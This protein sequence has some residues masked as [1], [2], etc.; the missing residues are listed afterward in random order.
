MAEQKTEKPTQQRLQ[1]A[2]R[3]GKFASSRDLYSAVQFVL[4]F[5]IALRSGEQIYRQM[6]VVFSS[7]IERAFSPTEL[8]PGGFMIIYT[9][10]IWPVFRSLLEDGAIVVGVALFLHLASTGF[11]MAAKQLLPDFTRLNFTERLKQMPQ[12]NF[13]A[14]IK[15]AV[16]LPIVAVI[17]YA[18]VSYRL[19]E[20]ANLELTSLG[21]GL[22]HAREMMTHLLWRISMALL[23]LALVDYAKQKR[24]F[25]S[26]LRMTKQEVKDEVKENEG[27]PQ[28]K[29]RIRRLQRDAARKSMMKAI[30]KATAVVVNPT[31]YA[32]AL[33]YEMNSKSIPMV[34]AKGKNYLAQLI[35]QRAVEHEI[36][37]IENQPL[38]KALYQAADVGQEIPADLY[39]A[40]A[41]V[42]AYIYRTLS[43][44]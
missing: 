35:R 32:V 33:Q 9:A 5:A 40:V 6:R 18:E 3:E 29:L 20:L 4:A 44:R 21:A 8:T 22:I 41:E 43:R 17:V 15:S 38:A 42:L 11:A 12:Q 10:S 34:V 27:N 37:I 7:L 31:H 1:K 39:R 13:S 2:R 28:M 30:P 19:P 26:G 14:L 16:L 36:P 24:K 25:S 23:V